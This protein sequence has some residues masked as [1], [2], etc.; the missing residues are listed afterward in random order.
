MKLGGN[1]PYHTTIVLLF[2]NFFQSTTPLSNHG[3]RIRNILS[4]ENPYFFIEGVL[5]SRLGEF[6]S[7]LLIQHLFPNT[8]SF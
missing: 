6:D 1:I 7:N 8:L 2:L 3:R 4:E 5:P